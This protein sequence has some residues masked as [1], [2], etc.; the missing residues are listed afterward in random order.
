[1]TKDEALA[2]DLALEALEGLNHEDSIFAGEFEKEIT[3]IKQVR[4]A[5][6]QEPFCF[7]YVENGEEYF[8][9][10]GAYVPDNAQPLYTTPPAQQE[11]AQKPLHPEIKKVFEDYFDKC[12]RALAAAQ[13]APLQD[14]WILVPVTLTNDMTSAMADALEDPEN[15]RSSW[16]LAE[17]M[18]RA[19]LPKVPTP[20]A[21][22]RT[23]VGLTDEDCKGMSAGD[24]VL[25]IWADRTLKEKNT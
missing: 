17:N 15:E 16:D 12:F 14:G 9:P 23:W 3:T 2:M 18:W 22:Q 8:A 11:P 7:V 21:A 6:V 5:P 4:L 13:P 10:K 24:R 20:P 1:M 25:A 19:M